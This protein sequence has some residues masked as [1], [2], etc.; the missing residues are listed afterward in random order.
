[1]EENGIESTLQLLWQFPNFSEP[2]PIKTN[3]KK[4]LFD[5]FEKKKVGVQEEISNFYL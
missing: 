4:R 5:F 1:M 2:F 3:L